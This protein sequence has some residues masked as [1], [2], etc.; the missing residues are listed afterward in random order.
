MQQLWSGLGED[1]GFITHTDGSCGRSLAGSAPGACHRQPSHRS[2]GASHPH[3]GVRD[4][5]RHGRAHT[6]ASYR[7]LKLGIEFDGRF[8]HE[9]PNALLA[10]RWRQNTVLGLGWRLLRFTWFDVMRRPQWVVDCV[11]RALGLEVYK[12][13]R[14]LSP[15]PWTV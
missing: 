7:D 12:R 15:L 10:D 4:R 13:R 6:S 1:G 9:Q 8:V 14:R 2:S 5:A 11:A 3:A